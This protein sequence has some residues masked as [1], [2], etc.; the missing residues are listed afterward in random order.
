MYFSYPSLAD[1]EFVTPLP[2]MK[3]NTSNLGYKQMLRDRMPKLLDLALRW[4]KAKNRWIDYVYE[5]I[6]KKNSVEKRSNVVKIILGI[7][8]DYKRQEIYDKLRYVEFKDVTR[9]QVNKIPK[10]ELYMKFSKTINWQKLSR[11]DPEMF[12][13]WK[14][15]TEWVDWFSKSYL[16]IEDTYKHSKRWGMS[17]IE[18]A[19]VLKDKYDIDINLANF[20]IKSFK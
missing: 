15:V 4:C 3:Q 20:L 7:K 10:S 11:E 19:I 2:T 5:N 6:V 1:K 18:I 14:I 17:D 13:Y 12:E 8:Q 16:Y 9:E